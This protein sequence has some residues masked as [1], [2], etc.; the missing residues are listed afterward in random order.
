MHP[1]NLIKLVGATSS[2]QMLHDMVEC[3]QSK[4]LL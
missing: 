3:L 1:A 2:M 4:Q